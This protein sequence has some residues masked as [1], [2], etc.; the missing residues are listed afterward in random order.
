MWTT[1]RVTEWID[2]LGI[3]KMLPKG[4]TFDYRMECYKYFEENEL[5]TTKN[6]IK[7]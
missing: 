6:F 7:A 5:L 2:R 3:K 1:K 4:I